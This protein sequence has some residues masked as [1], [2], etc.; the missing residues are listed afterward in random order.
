MSE[1][2]EYG[3]REKT[4]K[5]KVRDYLETGKSITPA[6]AYEMF[7]SMRLAAIICDLKKDGY[8]FHTEIVK[9]ENSRIKFARYKLDLPTTLFPS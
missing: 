8:K 1:I 5:E 9:K 2:R 6:E 4:K 7:G 3:K